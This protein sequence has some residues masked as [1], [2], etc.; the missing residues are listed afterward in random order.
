[1]KTFIFSF[2]FCLALCLVC[3]TDH[4]TVSYPL[5]FPQPPDMW[6][7]LL[8]K[9]HWRVEWFNSN[10]EK[11]KADVPPGRGLTVNVPGTWTNPVTAWPYWPQYGLIPGHFKPA[12]ALFPFDVHQEK[13]IVRWKAGPDVVLF[14]GLADAGNNARAPEHFDWPRFRELFEGEKINEAI[15]KDPWLVDWKAFAEKTAQSGFDQR[16]IVLQKRETISIPTASGPW[17]G[18]SP[19]VP[20]LQF[21]RNETPV[22]PVGQEVD[23]WISHEGILRANNKGWSLNAFPAF[24]ALPDRLNHIIR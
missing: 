15:R 8:G 4:L 5:Q 3:C 2:H 7:F 18:S 21:N 10:G 20:E 13:L 19:F 17:Y 23:V 12:G 9:P 11:Q 14:N 1:M 16:R 22:F 6:L 24:P